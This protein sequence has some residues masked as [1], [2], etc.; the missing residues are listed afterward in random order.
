M[1]QLSLSHKLYAGFGVVLLIAAASGIFTATRMSAIKSDAEKLDTELIP[2]IALA[3][4]IQKKFDDAFLAGRT[5]ALAGTPESRRGVGENL[6]EMEAAI[7]EAQAL[8]ATDPE[9][10]EQFG[11]SIAAMYKDEKDYRR[12]FNDTAEAVEARKAAQ[13]RLDEAAGVM[14]TAMKDLVVNQQAKLRSDLRGQLDVLADGERVDKLELAAETDAL[15]SDLRLAAFKMSA[16]NDPRLGDQVDEVRRQLDDRLAALGR[17]LTSPEDVADV[18]SVSDAVAT[19]HDGTKVIRSQMERIEQLNGQRAAVSDRLTARSAE[20][21]QLIFDSMRSVA[22][23]AS[24]GSSLS[25]TTTLIGLLAAVGG[26]G[27]IAFL[28]SRHITKSLS[29]AA[30]RLAQASEQTASASSEIA[31]GSQ[32]L[33]QGASEQAASLEETNS[34][35]EEMRSMTRRNADGAREAEKLASSA[36]ESASRGDSSMQEM[37]RAIEQIRESADETNKIIKTIDDIAFQ[38]NLLALNAAV[39]AARAGEAGKGFAVV[40]EEV[41][42]LAMRSAE[43]AKT[44]SDLIRQSVEASVSGESTAKQAA[45][46]LTEISEAVVKVNGLID[47]IAAASQEQAQGIDQVSKAVSQMD[48]VTQQNAANAEESAASSQEL[49]HQATVMQDAVDALG[50]LVGLASTR[51]SQ[52]RFPKESSTDGVAGRIGSGA[53][54]ADKHGADDF[55][56]F[57][58]MAA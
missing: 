47:E 45:S 41:R 27:A 32:S 9:R 30:T 5:Y 53:T 58:R 48:Q 55:A 22:D 3:T 54:S 14:A 29:A 2:E 20:E 43:A 7:E 34:S 52:T 23:E 19:Y 44:T 57:D 28:L 8:V 33:A 24:A 16:A 51:V 39:E 38:T 49:N 50:K 40:A 13:T 56:D 31:A 17:I 1:R 12:L 37:S 26:G 18:A 46:S 6:D 15:V 36:R 21:L 25:L 11:S 35:L 10:F 4:R 42:T